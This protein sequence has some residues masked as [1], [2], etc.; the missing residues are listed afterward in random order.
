MEEGLV[1]R[2]WTRK[3]EYVERLQIQMK[4]GG[5]RA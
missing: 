4:E 5:C 2:I 3:D 1:G